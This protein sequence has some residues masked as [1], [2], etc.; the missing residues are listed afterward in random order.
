MALVTRRAAGNAQVIIDHERCNMCRL[1][2]KVCTGIP[3]YEKDGCIEVDQSILLGCIGC[4]QCMAVCSRECITVKGRALEPEH[5]IKLPPREERA[6]Y[7]DLY[8]LMV[9]RRSIRRFKKRTIELEAVN[10]IIE[11]VRPH[12]AAALGSGN[13]GFAWL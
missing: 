11:A 4:G 13:S 6:G 1:C 7:D 5:A 3:L 10:Q 8:N 9:A 12:G 2:L